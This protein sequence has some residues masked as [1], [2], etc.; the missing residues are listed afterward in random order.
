MRQVPI[1]MQPFGGMANKMFQY[2]FCH[3]LAKRIP[4]GYV[5]DADLPEWSIARVRPPLFWKYRLLRVDGYHRYDLDGII[6]AF[7][8]RRARSIRFKGFAQRLGYYDRDEVSGLFDGRAVAAPTHG[9]DFLVIHVRAGDILDGFHRNYCPMPFGFFETLIKDSGRNPVF[10]GQTH[11]DND[12]CRRLRQ[13]FPDAVFAPKASPLTDF[14]TLRRASHLV[15]GVSSFSWLAGWLSSA[16]TIHLPV[17]GIF[18]RCIRPDIDL[19]PLD[20]PRYRFHQFDMGDWTGS[21]EQLAAFYGDAIP[22][23]QVEPQ[24]AAGGAGK[25]LR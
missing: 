18:D 24:A 10:V 7:R 25:A 20:D 4:G 3:V 6:A 11:D 16:R 2:M 15:T 23:R 1:V 13:R 14:E 8:D 19:L 22:F 17:A 5:C 9:D 12:Y 21:S